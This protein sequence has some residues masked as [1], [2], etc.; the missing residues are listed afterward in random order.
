MA[1]SRGLISGVQQGA[2]FEVIRILSECYMYLRTS[3]RER[4]QGKRAQRALCSWIYQ[5]LT[6]LGWPCDSTYLDVVV[7]RLQYITGGGLPLVPLVRC[8]PP[9]PKTAMEES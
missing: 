1:R 7:A 9:P 2:L 8:I 4:T 6:H 5:A 3:P